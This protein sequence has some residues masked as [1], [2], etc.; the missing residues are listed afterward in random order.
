MVLLAPAAIGPGFTHVTV[1]PDVVQLLPLLVKLAG[2]LVPLGNVNVVVIEP[3]VAPV[4]LFVTVTGTLLGEPATNAGEGCPIVVVRSAAF[5]TGE[6][7][8]IGLAALLPVLLSP[9]VVVVALNCGVVPTVPAFGF[10]G[11]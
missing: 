6:A 11:T 9:G 2:A 7:G 8:V 5:T 10:T 3:V 4:P 1:C